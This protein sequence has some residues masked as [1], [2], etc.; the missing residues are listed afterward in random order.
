M[1]DSREYAI[2]LEMTPSSH[3]GD[4]L[5][6]GISQIIS[7]VFPRGRVHSLRVLK[8]GKT[9]SNVLVRMENCDD[10]F[11]LR[12]HLRG[13]E[14]CRKEV[15][16]LQALQDVLSVPELIDADIT[17]DESG[18]RYL[19]YRYVPG[20][21][22]REIRDS[23]SSQDMA[24]AACAIG[25]CLSLLGNFKASSL[26]GSG[27]LARFGICEGDFDSPV[28]RKDLGLDDWLLLQRLHAE[29]LPVLQNLPSHGALIMAI[30]TTGI[31]C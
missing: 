10:L 20:Q 21:T 17:G 6:E 2:I 27:L 7:T 18:K 30:S 4:M 23:G 14:V 16:L 5:P 12:H 3:P 25:R 22:F 13:T 1:G 15:S 26:E 9:N 29:W 28:L 31:L 8:G 24:D 19:L 11:V